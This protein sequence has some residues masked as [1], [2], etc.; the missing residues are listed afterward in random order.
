MRPFL[1]LFG[2][3][4]VCGALFQKRGCGDDPEDC[5][6]E[7]LSINHCVDRKDAAVQN[8]IDQGLLDRLRFF[9]QFA[10]ASYWPGN[11]NSTGDLLKCSGDHCPKVPSGNCPDVEKADYMTISEW[12]DIQRFDDYG[13]DPPPKK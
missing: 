10:A 3:F 5:D 4:V 9:S 8:G 2:L 13:Q 7:F 11:N 1:L 6:L 12:K